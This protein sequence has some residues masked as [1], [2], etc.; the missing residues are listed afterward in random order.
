MDGR[1]SWPPVRSPPGPAPG[2]MTGSPFVSDPFISRGERH[3]RRLHLQAAGQERRGTAAGRSPVRPDFAGPGLRAQRVQEQRAGDRRLRR[4]FRPAHHPDH[5]LRG[6]P[7]RSAGA[8]TEGDVS[9]RALHRAARQHQ[10]LGQRGLPRRRQGH[11]QEAADHRRR[12]HRGVRRVPGAVGHR[13]GLRGVRRHRRVGHLQQDHARC[14][15]VTHG[16]RRRAVAGLVRDGLRA[17]P[18]LA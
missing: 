16:G 7:E 5:Q 17:A 9:R 10:R 12:G 2:R 8:G 15:L 3:E 1:R 14:G 6:R 18:R 13:G 11:R 4:V